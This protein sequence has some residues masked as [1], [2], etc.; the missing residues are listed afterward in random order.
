MR[1]L[2]TSRFGPLVVL[3]VPAV[4]LVRLVTGADAAERLSVMRGYLHDT[5]ET[6]ALEQRARDSPED[7]EASGWIVLGADMLAPARSEGFTD[8]I[9]IHGIELIDGYQRLKALARAQDERGPAHLERTFL[10]VEVHCGS[11]R[12]RARRMHGHADR[13]RNIRVARDRLLLCPHIQRLVR[14]NWEGWTFCVRRGVIAGPSGTT[15]CLTEVTRALACLSG[16]GPEL[17]HRTVSDEGLVS[18]W[19]DIGSPS[20]LS[21][22]HARMTPLGVMR[23]VESYRAARAALET[24]PKS[25][26]HQGHGRLMLHAP[27]LFHW[28]GCRFLPWERLHDSSSVFHWDD[29]LRNDMRGHMEAA[30]TELVRRYEQRVPVGENDRNIYYET[31]RELW[32]W[33]DLTRGL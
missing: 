11:E 12:E 29:A 30:V 24:L 13:Y 14:A 6:L 15:Y 33:Q 3:Y 5:P 26:R 4:E 28:A 25:R 18:L 1:P 27:Q 31:A 19:D 21:L 32:L 9:W 16:P 2:S 20:Y 22:F 10:K 7:F 17:V 8:R 23:A